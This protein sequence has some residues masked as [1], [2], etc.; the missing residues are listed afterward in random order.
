MYPN[1]YL[2]EKFGINEIYFH[3]H[4]SDDL[5]EKLSRRSEYTLDGEDNIVQKHASHDIL[6]IFHHQVPSSSIIY[7]F[8]KALDQ[9]KNKD[10]FIGDNTLLNGDELFLAVKDKSYVLVSY[11]KFLEQLN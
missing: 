9:D 7:R 6:F 2:L 1:N 11:K 3:P 10:S 5:L 8:L 4:F